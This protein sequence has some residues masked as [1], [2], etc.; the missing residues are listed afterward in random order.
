MVRDGYNGYLVPVGDAQSLA[1]HILALLTDPHKR[2]QLGHQAHEYSHLYS[3]EKISRR[4]LRVYAELL[5]SEQPV[6]LVN[7]V[8]A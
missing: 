4:L 6:K 2:E 3:W 7:R 1:D 5:P 8:V